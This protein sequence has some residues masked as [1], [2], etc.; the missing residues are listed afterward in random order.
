MHDLISFNILL[1]LVL[2]LCNTNGTSYSSGTV[3]FKLPRCRKESLGL[4]A[5]IFLS[6]LVLNK[7][8]KQYFN[9]FLNFCES[10]FSFLPFLKNKIFPI[11]PT[12]NAS[13]WY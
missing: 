2:V 7:I 5:I 11:N 6:A 4:V 13:G 3:V 8:L 12:C 10:P 9:I 1:L